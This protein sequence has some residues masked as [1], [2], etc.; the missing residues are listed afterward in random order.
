MLGYSQ[1][2]KA[3]DFDSGMRRFES[4]YPSQFDPLAQSVEHLTF[5]QGVRSSNLRWVTTIWRGTEAVITGRS[6][7]PLESYGSQGFESLPLRQIKNQF[8]Y[9]FLEKYSS[10]WRGS[11]AKGVDPF[12]RDARVQIPPSPPY[13]QI[14]Q[15]VEQGTEN[16]RVGGSIPPLG[17]K[18]ARLIYENYLIFIFRTLSFIL[19]FRIFDLI[20]V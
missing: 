11:P 19:F 1:V 2:G 8:L 17:T 9:W 14:A 12:K 5:N 3:P 7:K 16:P 13:A 18:I 4:C 15:S 20:G 10:G 6:W